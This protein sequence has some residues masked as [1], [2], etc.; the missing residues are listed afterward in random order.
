[1]ITPPPDPH[2]S[3]VSSTTTSAC[4]VQ[5]PDPTIGHPS[6]QPN[7]LDIATMPVFTAADASSREFIK[8]QSTTDSSVAFG[9]S[10]LGPSSSNS[11]L[12]FRKRKS[13]DDVWMESPDPTS[14]VGN[15]EGASSDK[16]SSS[17]PS[18]VPAI[19]PMIRR[20]IFGNVVLASKA[21]EADPTTATPTVIP[22]SA[23]VSAE[24]LP[25]SLPLAESP[26]A[27]PRLP[28]VPSS[29][30]G[31]HISSP[32][33]A[34]VPIPD[35]ATTEEP[36]STEAVSTVPRPITFNP[37]AGTTKSTSNLST[38]TLPVKNAVEV[39]VP[40]PLI[41]ARPLLPVVSTAT[42]VQP[43]SHPVDNTSGRSSE[44][45]SLTEMKLQVPNR[46]Q[47]TCAAKGI[48]AATVFPRVV[49]PNPLPAG[50]ILKSSTAT[51]SVGKNAV[52]AAVS[53]STTSTRPT[54]PSSPVAFGCHLPTGP[55][56][57]STERLLYES[58]ELR[59]DHLRRQYDRLDQAYQIERTQHHEQMAAFE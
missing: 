55:P 57:I 4:I 9:K 5:V 2:A 10:S 27:Q 51:T 48:E 35:Q 15:R 12:G 52:T 21:P 58:L 18:Q 47:S 31:P 28:D 1:M 44:R 17:D 29:S 22:S 11:F 39:P 6:S 20:A 33:E 16:S 13:P 32:S 56:R 14:S 34:K 50:L 3:S 38:A 43:A 7:P 41:S 40:P 8:P 37:P 25:S 49:N 45:P 36:K 53:T 24:K 26:A 23:T 19:R 59:Y 54:L 30:T 46:S 42:A